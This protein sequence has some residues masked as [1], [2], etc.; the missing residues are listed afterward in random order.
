MCSNQT[1]CAP[2]HSPDC[3]PDCSPDYSL[4]SQRV[5]SIFDSR[6]AL[7]RY[8]RPVAD[9]CFLPK[10]GLS[11]TI[12]S[13]ISSANS[14]DNRAV[15]CQGELSEQ[16]RVLIVDDHE[17][18][19][20]LARYVVE[21]EGYHTATALCAEDAV[22]IAIAYRPHLILLDI[23]LGNVSGIDVFRNIKQYEQFS[24]V[25]VVGVTALTRDDVRQEA[26]EI[27]FAD[28]LLKP[29]NIEDLCQIVRTYCGLCLSTDRN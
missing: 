29:Y 10:A 8:R 9:R 21:G 25:P 4:V 6:R 1:N 23:V 27:G 7:R 11:H 17:D 24:Q 22:D 16:K 2:N 12:P 13:Y 18:S 20:M 19:L 3:S 15:R 5:Y 14:Y 26:I 28:Y